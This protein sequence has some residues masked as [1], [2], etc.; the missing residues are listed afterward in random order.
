MIGKRLRLLN[1]DF[2]NDD[3]LPAVAA[4]DPSK[5]VAIEDDP[6]WPAPVRGVS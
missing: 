1:Y 4:A 6:S 5:R 3:K 2:F